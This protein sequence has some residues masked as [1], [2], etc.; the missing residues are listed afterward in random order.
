MNQYDLW[1]FPSETSGDQKQVVFIKTSPLEEDELQLCLIPAETITFQTQFPVLYKGEK[2]RIF[3][4]Y[5]LKG[6]P[7]I[8]A[9]NAIFNRY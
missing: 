7:Q 4:I 6:L 3:Y 8:E 2:I 5:L 9:N 1:G